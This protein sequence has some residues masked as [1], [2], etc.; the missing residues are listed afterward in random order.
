MLLLVTTALKVLKGVGTIWLK[1]EAQLIGLKLKM[2][3]KSGSRFV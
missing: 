1:R 3:N 2:S